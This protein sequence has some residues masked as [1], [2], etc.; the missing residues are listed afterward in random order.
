MAAEDYA[1]W[2]EE[3][4]RLIIL[5]DLADPKSGGSTN[6]FL[7]QKSLERFSYRKSRDYIR[8][9]LLWLE[10]EAGALRTRTEGT[11]T[12]AEITRRGRD[13]VERRTILAGVQ[14]PGDAE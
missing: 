6:T 10:N 1:K 4:I 2:V 11:E 5:K 9:Q 3:N 13:H 12:S 14:A 8:N 7:V